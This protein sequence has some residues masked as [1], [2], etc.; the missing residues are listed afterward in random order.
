MQRVLQNEGSGKM[1]ITAADINNQSFSIDRKGYDVDEVDVFLEHVA[2]E[3]DALNFRIAQLEEESRNLEPVGLEA[4]ACAVDAAPIS[5]D[6]LAERDEYIADL[7]RQLKE[8]KA[9]D[10]AIA[11]ALII[12]QRSADEIIS[13]ANAQGAATIQDAEDEA[14][15]IVKKAENEKQRIVD[16]IEK[17]EEDR[18]KAR[19]EYQDLL[20]GFID[21]AS[22]KLA[23]ISAKESAVQ[24]F[25][26]GSA[27]AR[28]TPVAPSG[29]SATYVTPQSVS[30]VVIAPATPKPSGTEKDFSGFG[31]TD[32]AFELEEL[33]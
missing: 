23:E 4:S 1:A 29:D 7:K 9:D 20:S 30:G 31:D 18:E 22:D 27:H 25:I 33:D 21:D 32:D 2:K 12:A 6:E 10:N 5:S 19:K 14:D 8:K 15:R 11:Q 17:L 28:I 16:V 13:N 24:S 3:I 26:A